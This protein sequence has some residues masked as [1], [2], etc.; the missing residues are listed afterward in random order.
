MVGVIAAGLT[1]IGATTYFVATRFVRKRKGAKQ[2][3]DYNSEME[4]EE[5]DFLSDDEELA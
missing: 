4:E 5:L 1:L 2:S 3:K